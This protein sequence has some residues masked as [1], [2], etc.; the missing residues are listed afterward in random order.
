M[1]RFSPVR[2][3]LAGIL[4][5]SVLHAKPAAA[6]Q[7]LYT[8]PPPPGSAQLRF[9]NATTQPLALHTA[10]AADFKLGTDDASRVSAYSVVPNVAHRSF[11]I[12]VESAGKP[13]SITVQPP[14]DSQVTVLI[15]D[16]TGIKATSVIDEVEFN[17]LRTRLRFYNAAPQCK[18]AGLQLQPGGQ[19]IFS[20][21]ASGAA[22]MRAVNPVTANLLSTCNAANG[23]S[24]QLQGLEVGRGYSLW[25]MAPGGVLTSF[26]SSDGNSLVQP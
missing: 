2:F 5:G 11:A 4:F 1:L 23:P 19:S 20:D 13:Y 8:P 9:V 7:V 6:Q 21:V 10:F 3:V 17:Q 16:T 25:L 22:K 24:V 12:V 26:V 15:T 14:P 18:T